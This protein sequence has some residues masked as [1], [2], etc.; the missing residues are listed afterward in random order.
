MTMTMKRLRNEP[1]VLLFS[2][3]LP[4]EWLSVMLT[5]IYGQMNIYLFCIFFEPCHSDQ[6]A[7]PSSD[8]TTQYKCNEMEMAHN[9]AHGTVATTLASNEPDYI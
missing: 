7:Q 2:I 1:W 5:Y 4:L 9:P 3:C 8:Y 6:R